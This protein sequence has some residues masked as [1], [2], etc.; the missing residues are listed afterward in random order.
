MTP[1]ETIGSYRI[2]RAIG[3]G[4]MGTVYLGEHRALGR[5]AAIK[6]LLPSLSARPDIVQRFFNEARAATA[7]R[8]PGIVQ[9]FD[10][11]HDANGAYIVMELLEGEPLAARLERYGRLAPEDAMRI[12]RQVASALGAAHRSGIVHRDLK[13]DNIFIV[14]DPEVPSGE[15]AKI[16]DFG[17]A[18]LATD[19]AGSA[20]TQL[21]AIMGTPA[22]MSPEQCRGAGEIDA[23]SDIYSLGCVLFHLLTGSQ[24]F[25]SEG[26]GDVIA[27]HLREA[28]RAPSQIASGIA[29]GLDALVLRCL[30]KLPFD[31]FA[32]MDTVVAELDVLRKASIPPALPA[33]SAHLQATVVSAA[34]PTTLSS[35]AGTAAMVPT[36]RSRTLVAIG[37]VVACAAMVAVMV[38]TS[39]GSH[40]VAP[41]V[42]PAAPPIDAPLADAAWVDAD[43]ASTIDAYFVDAA[44]PDAPSPQKALPDEER[45][46]APHPHKPT[47][48]RRDPC[49]LDGDG[50]PE[51]RC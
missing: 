33:S 29:P 41:V 43:V 13:P 16:L 45:R 6:V 3:E 49:D 17:I 18:K 34:S 32:S 20:K 40:D 36:N 22:Y 48:P 12:A 11:G 4:G 9:V 7:I 23:R 37:G 21:G 27:M 26:V 50:I 2:L 35:A 15:R 38:S 5:R 28:P 51:K 31:R 8:D 14:R 30:H 1:P 42:E 39:R 47:S 46:R 24:P 10:F 44:T 25:E 19:Q